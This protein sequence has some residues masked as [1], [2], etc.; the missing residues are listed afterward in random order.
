MGDNMLNRLTRYYVSAHTAN[1]KVNYLQS[2]IKGI[3]NIVSIR[4][5]CNQIKTNLFHRFINYLINETDKHVEVIQ[6]SDRRYD[7][8]G[9]IVRE[10]TFAVFSYDLLNDIS[11]SN[12]IELD[13]DGAQVFHDKDK[14]NK[15][16][17][18]AYQYFKESLMIHDELERIYI[19]EMDFKKADEFTEQFIYTHFKDVKKQQGKRHVYK[20]LFGSNT[21]DGSHQ[22][23]SHLIKPIKYRYFIKGRAGTGKSHFMRAVLKACRRL[24]L[25]VEVYYCSFD[26]S[27]IDMLIIRSLDCCFFDSTPPHEFFPS[28]KTDKVIDLY[29]IAVQ[30]NTDER[31]KNEI[32]RVTERYRTKFKRGL[33]VL[34]QIK[35]LTY[36]DTLDD[37]RYER[38]V[39]QLKTYINKTD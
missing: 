34:N 12:I 10:S 8:D 2:N 9:V 15:Y 20:R 38:I 1:G 29:E 22:L 4:S 18:E 26:P 3:K 32:N 37:E 39:D 19:N 31:F 24:H 6:N 14:K 23:I 33:Q 17:N 16:L 30:P 21:A 35:Q 25:D 7:L 5:N 13:I 28:R 27:S 36:H 11:H